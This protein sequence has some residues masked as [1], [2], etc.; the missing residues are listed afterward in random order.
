VHEWPFGDGSGGYLLFLGRMHPD[1]GPHRAIALAREAGL[2]LVLA[3]KLREQ[4]ELDFFEQQVRPLLHDDTHFVGEAD[5]DTKRRLLAGARCLLNP[6]SWPEPFGMVMVEALACGTP[7]VTPPVGAAPE[8]VEHGVTGFLC[9]TPR[10]TRA[11]I[12]EVDQLDRS[13][14]REAVARRFTVD[15]MVN[16]YLDVYRDAI[17]DSVRRRHTVPAF[18]AVEPAASMATDA[19]ACE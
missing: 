16:G 3:G 7:V 2:P 14:C 10:A 17:D 11:A 1:K 18:V 13:R 12:Q 19:V 6:I 4:F 8:I 9:A 15:R 5:A